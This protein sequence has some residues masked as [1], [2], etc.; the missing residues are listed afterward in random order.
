[1]PAVVLDEE[2]SRTLPV[3]Q[4]PCE[5]PDQRHP[6]VDL[7]L[8]EEVVEA[9]GVLEVVERELRDIRHRA[10]LGLSLISSDHDQFIIVFSTTFAPCSLIQNPMHVTNSIRVWRWRGC[11]TFLQ[12]P[13]LIG[14]VSRRLQCEMTARWADDACMW[15]MIYMPMMYVLIC[16]EST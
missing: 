8:R 6:K 1:M 13:C 9:Q 14:K 3:D 10:M 2:M 15:L 12:L 11:A 7:E 5:D 16:D 4:Q